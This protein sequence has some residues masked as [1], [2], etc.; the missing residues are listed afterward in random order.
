MSKKKS[1]QLFLP[2]LIMMGLL[3]LMGLYIYLS[4]SSTIPQEEIHTEINLQADRSKAPLEELSQQI[5]NFRNTLDQIQLQSLADKGIHNLAIKDTQKI[6]LDK[7]VQSYL[8]F[9][10]KTYK[11]T[12]YLAQEN[13]ILR[14][15]QYNPQ[16]L[17]YQ[18]K[19]L[20]IYFKSTEP[21][22]PPSILV[23]DQIQGKIFWGGFFSM[24]FFYGF[25]F[26]I[27]SYL[28]SRKKTQASD[29]DVLLAGRSIPLWIA[30]F[31]MSATWIGGGYINGAAE[32]TY[33]SG[34]V[35]VQAPW[36]YALSLII[37]GLFFAK[38]MRRFKFRTML[39]P[40]AQRFG[41]RMTAVL[42]LPA[43]FGE[44]FWTAA[45]LSALGSTFGIVLGIGFEESILLSAF[46][47]IAYTA[48]G[49]LWAVALTD[50]LQMLLLL[51][52]LGLTL[53]YAVEAVGGWDL[54]WSS[55]EQKYTGGASL[56]PSWESLGGSYF[57][58]W[59][60]ALLLI[61]GGIP[62]QV[63]FQRVLSAKNESTARN[64]SI[65]A[66]VICLLA[67]IPPI[68]IGVVGSAAVDNLSIVA[69][70]ESLQILPEIMQ[71]LTPTVIATIGLGAIA[72]A[73]MSSADSSILSASSMASWNIY[74]PLINP[75]VKS[76]QLA[77][78]I[79]RCIWIIGIAATLI[80][81][82]VKS[83]Y[84]LWFLCADF[85]Y[86]LL[87]PA[88]VCALFDKKANVYGVAFGFT[89][90]AFIRFS[91]GDATLGIPT[92]IDYSMAIEGDPT[93]KSIELPFRTFAM[94]AGLI[95]IILVSRLT[96]GISPARSLTIVQ[97]EENPPE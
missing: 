35:W 29:E 52:G 93:V 87:F 92:L 85:V 60:Y 9:L 84:S 91:G 31:T 7:I 1:W 15:N 75:R 86:C 47:A 12:Q 66:G 96:Q 53:P 78:V 57:T 89:V 49:G 67:A 51:L 16:L 82:Q 13:A 63:Y 94:L 34:L 18:S 17:D 55:Y 48:L 81:L 5:T 97:E 83:V 73:V 27:G 32:A 26:F 8:Q 42:F 50:V 95:G 70:A 19:S 65:F 39:D 23:I 79:K 33:N 3:S 38:K 58:W 24:L 72:A 56:L 2:T 14:L 69:P 76:E 45:I 10:P 4:N 90:A 25:I 36:G 61:F 30:V 37:G 43:L 6:L 21:N 41:Q 77:K 40:L 22:T 64:L 71:N 74:R 88:L 54:A 44:L 20:H 80:A 46:I 62:W 28:A 68:V 11:K 59:D